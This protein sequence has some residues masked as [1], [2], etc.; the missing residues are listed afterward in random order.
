MT[1]T[2]LLSECSLR[3]SI[4]TSPYKSKLY[5][6]IQN[7]LTQAIT[8]LQWFQKNFI[9]HPKMQVFL[10]HFMLYIMFLFVQRGINW[11]NCPVYFILAFIVQCLQLREKTSSSWFQSGVWNKVDS[12][13]KMLIIWSC[14]VPIYWN[15]PKSIWLLHIQN[16]REENLPHNRLSLTVRG[17]LR[18][19]YPLSTNTTD[20]KSN[21]VM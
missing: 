15:S 18:L 21:V 2:I 9:G 19:Y 17:S 11:L 16:L 4:N 10:G 5:N 3:P 6:H 13:L 7:T 12:E 14:H 8:L 1:S 20:L